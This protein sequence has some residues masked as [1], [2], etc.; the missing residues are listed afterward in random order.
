MN[1]KTKLWIGWIYLGLGGYWASKV[2][3]NFVIDPNLASKRFLVF[4]GVVTIS[5]VGLIVT[6]VLIHFK[7]EKI[8]QRFIKFNQKFDTFPSWLAWILIVVSLVLPFFIQVL[9]SH[10]VPEMSNLFKDIHY[11]L[12]PAF[13]LFSAYLMSK[14][15]NK[16]SFAYG[17]LLCVM[18]S[19]TFYH[20]AFYFL[21]VVSIPFAL[22]WSEGNRLYD[23][24]VFFGADRY[25]ILDGSLF[26][27]F[28]SAGRAFYYGLIYLLPNVGIQGVRFW[29]ALVNTLPF[30]LLGWLLVRIDFGHK[31]TK[32]QK[33]VFVIWA[34]LFI[35]QGPI[36]PYFIMALTL[37]FVGAKQKNLVLA[38]ILV[39]F[40][41]FLANISRWTWTFAPGIY[42]GM[43]ALLQLQNPAFKNGR[44]KELIR[45]FVLGISGLIGGLVFIKIIP[46]KEV[47]IALFEDS[48]GISLSSVSHSFEQSLL[49]YR[50]LP[51]RTFKPGILLAVF[52]AIVFLYAILT[53]LY[54][55]KK[56]RPNWLQLLGVGAFQLIFLGVGIVASTKIGGGGD[57][58]NLDM[59]LIGSLIIAASAWNYLFDFDFFQKKWQI[60]LLIL[61]LI[62]PIFSPIQR[63]RV[64]IYPDA[65][66]NQAILTKIQ[67]L[68]DGAKDE[69]EILFMDERQLLTFGY[70]VDVPLVMDYEKKYI[71][72]MAMA[73]NEAYFE[74]YQ[75]DIESHRFAMI[76]TE[77]LQLNLY[78]PNSPFP[79]ENTQWVTWVPKVI[80]DYYDSVYKNRDYNIEVFVPKK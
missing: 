45:P 2:V 42:A 53:V 6:G 16:V 73:D 21:P 12:I 60:G 31:L 71:N 78:K 39:A 41:G 30:F 33:F 20:V 46:V 47:N 8:I 59:F 62:V 80:F 75:A 3:Y 27:T 9:I 65:E 17:L 7:H 19:G 14:V 24:S 29:Q 61:M 36:H 15:Q 72:D 56:W 77:T 74:Q 34:Y 32:L 63:K 44:W 22:G 76:V 25:L 4:L 58:H 40:G 35:M 55:Q 66:K 1:N 49:W 68:V 11:L 52:V 79:E 37:T 10:I 57:L 51:N 67:G 48:V 23:Y 26:Q 64:P 38:A 43:I 70:I 5:V 50:L 28:I 54:R 18:I 69:G 13:A